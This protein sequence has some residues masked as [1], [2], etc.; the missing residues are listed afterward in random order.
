MDLIVSWAVVVMMA[1]LSAILLSGR[2]SFL[3][4]GYN[5]SSKEEK[6]KYNEKKL[7]RIVGGGLG[8]STV[9]FA[10]FTGYDFDLPAY[11]S[12]IMPWGLFAVIAVMMVLTNTICKKKI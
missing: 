10:V 12:W 1:V 7:C 6:A 8:L 9:I 5:T 2:G 11:I 4:A 3:I